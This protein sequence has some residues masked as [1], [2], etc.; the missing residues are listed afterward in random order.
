MRIEDKT[1]NR[2][3]LIELKGTDLSKAIEQID[4]TVVMFKV[5]IK[6]YEKNPRIV[7]KSNTHKVHNSAVRNFKKFKSKY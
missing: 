2:V 6:N 3:F 4:A 1:N 5:L 7:Y